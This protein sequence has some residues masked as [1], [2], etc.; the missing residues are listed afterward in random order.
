MSVKAQ[1]K[2]ISFSLGKYYNT[3]HICL[4][5]QILQYSTVPRVSP[6]W[7]KDIS[8]KNRRNTDMKHFHSFNTM[9]IT[10][11][12]LE[13]ELKVFFCV[14]KLIMRTDGGDS[15]S[16]NINTHNDVTGLMN[17]TRV[18]SLMDSLLPREALST[19]TY[20]T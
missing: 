13:F 9:Q 3:I 17:D 7:M 2:Y 12:C 8:T 1:F 18:D 14:L 5:N 6:A 10:E 16:F 4:I 20:N 15:P 19:T 11:T